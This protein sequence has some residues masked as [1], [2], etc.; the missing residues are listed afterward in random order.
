MV[1]LLSASCKNS[2]NG[3]D[4]VIAFDPGNRTFLTGYDGEN[5]LEIGS[6]DIGHITRLCLHLDKLIST[7]VKAKGKANKKLRYKL[8]QAIKLR[9]KIQDLV[10]DM[11]STA[12]LIVK[13]QTYLPS[14][15]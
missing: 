9:Y 5:I 10:D 7:H 6:G 13:L 14:N 15:L 4:K 1:C 3:S 11:H 8:G 2:G 12:S